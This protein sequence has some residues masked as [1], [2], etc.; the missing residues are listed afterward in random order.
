MGL[1]GPNAKT[2]RKK[3]ELP[4]YNLRP[5]PPQDMTVE[6][7]KVWI[8]IIKAAPAGYCNPMNQHLLQAYCESAAQH[9]LGCTELEKTGLICVNEKSGAIKK[10]PMLAIVDAAASKMATLST[11]LSL[12]IDLQQRPLPTEPRKKSRF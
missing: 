11:K 8:T 1:R 7:K 2:A 3:T 12:N 9:S 10:H 6:G 4:N 5:K